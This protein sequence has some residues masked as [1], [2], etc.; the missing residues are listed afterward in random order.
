[1]NAV[2]AVALAV[3]SQ[4]WDA[5]EFSDAYMIWGQSTALGLDS[6]F[7]GAETSNTAGNKS[8]FE[9]FY[10]QVGCLPSESAWPLHATI[11]TSAC[12]QPIGGA[13]YS[14]CSGD[15]SYVGPRKHIGDF[16]TQETG[17]KVLLGMLAIPGVPY[18]PYFDFSCTGPTCYAPFFS[19]FF[20]MA[21]ARYPGLRV[22]AV[23][24]FHGEADYDKTA[25]TYRAYME[26]LYTEINASARR[27]V[28]GNVGQ[29]MPLYLT[30]W[31][32]C[33]YVG[34]GY[35]STLSCGSIQGIV[36]AAEN[37][38][39][40]IVYVGPSYQYDTYNSGP[41]LKSLDNK[42]RGAK[43]VQAE[44]WG[45]TWTG[46]RSSSIARVGN[47]YVISYHVPYPPLVFDTTWVTDPSSG[48]DKGFVYVESD[49]VTTRAK[50][51]QDPVICTGAGAPHAACSSANQVVIEPVAAPGGT[52][53][54]IFYASG[55]WFNS[56]TNTLWTDS[57]CISPGNVYVTPGRTTGQRGNLRDMDPTMYLGREQ[58]NWAAHQGWSNLP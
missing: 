44:L 31:S 39:G 17:R 30:Q 6:G 13:V 52:T 1:M 8:P 21:G 34:A 57:Q 40:K 28:S 35:A 55:C 19:R 48:G 53:R 42:L 32:S 43:A 41:H 9:Y 49:G 2:L 22:R 24:G 16:F 5:R 23:L 54:Y 29:D 36:D 11:D 33:S 15:N 4:S 51:I 20:E 50:A 47:A 46:V 3:L 58:R 27:R 26:D 7:T 56:G 25:A 18:S 14:S 10:A 37:N 12:T 45:P 38:A